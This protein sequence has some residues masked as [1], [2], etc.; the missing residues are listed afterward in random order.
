MHELPDFTA[1]TKE[2]IGDWFLHNDT[3]AL[4]SAARSPS[5]PLIQ[6]DDRDVPV[7][8]PA[9]FRLPP[10]MLDWLEQAAGRDREGKSGIVRR[11]L[12]EYRERHQGSVA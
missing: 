1:M 6:V 11:A 2:E 10:S 9:T 7:M 4:L 3:S 8:R 12:Q 5:E